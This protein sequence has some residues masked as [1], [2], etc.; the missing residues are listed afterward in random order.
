MASYLI[1]R[2][3]SN[4]AWTPESR[5]YAKSKLYTKNIFFNRG[6]MQSIPISVSAGPQHYVLYVPSGWDIMLSKMEIVVVQ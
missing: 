6:N 5:Q 4:I 1:S 3:T 2:L